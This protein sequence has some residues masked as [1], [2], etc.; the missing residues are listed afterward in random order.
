MLIPKKKIGGADMLPIVGK[1]L[2]FIPAVGK[3]V[4]DK[5]GAHFEED[6][7]AKEIQ[8]K[9]E[10]TEAEAFKKSGRIA[11]RY[12]K[13]YVLIGIAVF[14]FLAVFF[15][16]LLP[17]FDIDWDAPLRVMREIFAMWGA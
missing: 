2:G 17:T 6:A 14:V 1:L 7:K 5:M 10:L 13:Q 15:D 12:A 8:A 16:M 3:W 4:A 9:I 11:P